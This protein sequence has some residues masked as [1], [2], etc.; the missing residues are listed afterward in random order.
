MNLTAKQIELLRVIG[1]GNGP[2][3]PCDLDEILERVRYE[4]TK[5]SLQFSIRALVGH[6][7]IEKLPLEK[8]RG[9]QRRPIA[10]TELGRGYAGAAPQAAKVTVTPEEDEMDFVEEVL[11]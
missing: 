4:T 8:R 11:E 3:N 10:V 2:N 1:A 9:S 6:G 7:L 5:A